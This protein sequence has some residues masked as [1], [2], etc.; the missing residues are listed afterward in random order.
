MIIRNAFTILALVLATA[1]QAQYQNGDYVSNTSGNWGTAT[2]WKIYNGVSLATSPLAGSMPNATHTVYVRGGTTV[3]AVF[4]TTYSAANLIVE[5][6][7]KLFN[8]NTGP[9]NLSYIGIY[10]TTITCDGEIGN[11]AT[12][13][14]ISFNIEG[15]AVVLSGAGTFNAARIRKNANSNPITSA[16]LT[17]TNFTI[18]MD[19]NLRFSGGTNTMIYNNFTG[20]TTFN[21]IISAGSTVSLMVTGTPGAGNIAMDGVNG[22]GIGNQAGSYTVNGTLLIPGT[23]YMT[24]NNAA[25]YQCR[26]TINNGGY[27]RTASLNANA[28]TAGQHVLT[29]NAGGTLE[30]T[31]T[32]T[33]WTAYST[34]NNIYS[35]N[36]N[37]RVIYSGAGNQDVRGI[38][39]GYGH[40]RILGT[41]TKSLGGLTS[42]RGEL[43]IQN[44]SGTPV[45]DA[46][47]S[48]FGL[49]V[50]GNWTNYN[51]SGFNERNGI[52]TF[53][54]TAAPQTITTTGGEEFYTWRFSKT[55]AQPLVTMFSDVQV[56][57][58]VELNTAILDLNG[59]QLTVLN[60]LATA[61]SSSGGFSAQR[62][63]RSERTD[64]LSRVRWD[65]G[66]TNGA[67]LV[68]FGTSTAYTPF[69]FNLVS[70][71]AG[72]V[73]MATYGTAADNLPWPVT[74]TAVTNLASSI[75]LSPDNRDA[76]VDRFW[77]VDVTG[78]DP[79]AGL[80]F[81]YAAT[82][83]P[84]APWNDPFS[85]KAQRWN[86]ASQ[87]WEMQIEGNSAAYSALT[88][89][90]VTAFGPFTL[91][92]VLSPLPVELISFDA[93]PEGEV[94]RLDWLT[95]SE[96][97]NDFFTVLRSA[98]GFDFEEVLTVDGA[99]I[100][101]VPVAYTGVDRTPL[102]GTSY[103]KLRQTDSNGRSEESGMV[104]VHFVA[105]D[106][107]NVYP[108]PVSDM[109]VASGLADAQEVRILDAAGRVV[110][111]SRPASGSERLILSLSALPSG[112]YVLTT[113][114]AGGTR[115][116]RFVRE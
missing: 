95:A 63:I 46:T 37:S 107:L 104:A 61:I 96:R 79:T 100:S 12:L 108:N 55:V 18:A 38:A 76:T 57:N 29:I 64:N 11:G 85:M 91:S 89:V 84:L 8:N 88:D 92:P 19:V 87:E 71:D 78:A 54:G 15:S 65:I 10:G 102:P 103:Y 43:E 36:A 20:N 90:V 93:K 42:V 50:S 80:T 70:G 53:A 23:L 44:L 72:S 82:E 83:L 114:D 116:V 25:T 41:G 6:G 3:T 73:T 35:L 68:P 7:G 22:T 4:G 13:D 2:T 33:A 69:T 1:V 101:N 106:Q 75:G 56:A 81:T 21:V 109:L 66:T 17:L 48:N 77:Q 94:V 59:Y 28:S 16:A 110:L 67:H 39:G 5:A 32:P 115:S 52:V 62:H 51:Q 26:M 112:S 86:A 49:N 9:T 27:V 58:N 74:P 60:P 99:G 34:T 30:I 111:T 24:T 47:A 113:T 45:L 105:S 31:G 98:D 14:G 97:D 40:L